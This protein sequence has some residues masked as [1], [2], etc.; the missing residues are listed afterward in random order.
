M[1]ISRAALLVA[2]GNAWLAGFVGLDEVVDVVQRGDEP[3]QVCNELEDGADTAP[4]PLAL[5]LGQLR[6]ADATRFQLA[7]PVPGDV[8]SL[9]GP[10]EMNRLA[11]EAGEVALVDGASPC[12]LIPQVT[13]HGSPI[14]GYAYSVTWRLVRSAAPHPPEISPRGAAVQL[15]D[16]LREATTMLTQLDVA[17][18]GQQVLDALARSRDQRPA[19]GLPA[20]HPNAAHDLVARCE[21]LQTLL[22]LAA[23]DDGAA[24]TQ[25]ELRTRAEVL[26]TLGTAVRRA[27]E[28]AYS[29]CEAVAPGRPPAP[30]GTA[31]SVLDARGSS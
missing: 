23:S 25:Q 28:V 3:H 14:D 6:T 2:W 1:T 18:A 7:L 26:R 17:G 30:R 9:P 15:T 5:A 12:A 29:S 16:A 8:S 4:L 22:D 19:A 11:L 21:R 31:R 10:A 13:A 20:G 27:Q 24:V